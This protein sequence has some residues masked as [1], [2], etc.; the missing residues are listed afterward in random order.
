MAHPVPPRVY[1]RTVEVRPGVNGIEVDYHLEI[2]PH[3]IFFDVADLVEKEEL[4]EI[5]SK[6]AMY[7]AFID[8]LAPIVAYNLSTKLNG[9]E[10]K[11]EV[12]QKSY[13]EKDHVRC[14][15]Q[16]RAEWKL[17]A[18]KEHDFRFVENTYLEEKG[19]TRVSLSVN[20]SL[21]VIRSEAPSE[22]LKTKPLIDFAPG[23]EGRSRRV[24]ATIAI[25]A[26]TPVVTP[27]PKK[28]EPLPSGEEKAPKAS[29]LQQLLL[30][31]HLQ[32]W[33]LGLALFL[34]AGHA[35]TPGHGKTLVAAYLV[36]EKGTIGH[37]I[38]LGII[39]T[40]THTGAVLIVAAIIPWVFPSISTKDSIFTLE[41]VG[42]LLI[43]LMGLWLLVRRI[44][45]KAD[46]IH[47]GGGHHHH[48]HH[49]HGHHHHHHDHHHHDPEKPVRLKDLV[50]LGIAGGIVPC[51]EAIFLLTMAIR[52]QR[53]T[54]AFP[55]LLAFSAGLALVLVAVGIGVVYSKQLTSRLLKDR[56]WFHGAIRALPILSAVIITV[57][58]VWMCYETIHR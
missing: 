33:M 47:I 28:E 4:Q 45:G 52:W 9:K 43:L 6:A 20:G 15:F 39:T 16:L 24:T 14:T 11:L 54:M 36:G 42:G 13:E 35:L 37:A 25:P 18:D 3:T 30:Q 21:K 17:E 10:L 51:P 40:L 8:K 56:S 58:G 27:E 19:R 57:L 5:T 46:H 22:E 34:G 50:V 31:G 38:L 32:L 44:S 23:D 7:Q 55:L 29:A 26:S 41:L 1:D 12:A 2:D 49:G 48:H 53:T